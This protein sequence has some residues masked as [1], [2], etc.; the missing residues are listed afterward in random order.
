MF[1]CVRVVLVHGIFDTGKSMC[2]LAGALDI[3]GH[4]C[5]CPDLVPYD[6]SVSLEKLAAQ[7][8]EFVDDVIQDAESFALV[9]FSM[10]A[11]VSRIYLQ[12]LDGHRRVVGFFSISGPHSGSLMAKFGKGAGA[13]ELRP[14]SPLLKR[15]KSEEDRLSQVQIVSYWTPFD[16]MVFPPQSARWSSAEEH[17]AILALA[18]PLL[19]R[20]RKLSRDLV[21]R[22]GALRE[23]SAG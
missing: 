16:F 13:K 7:L 12:E 3:E 10:G 11:M 19:L 20:S 8:A 22:I 5:F 2:R 14:G 18:H 17:V 1:E 15:L 9:G 4:Q 21:R 23:E 6:G